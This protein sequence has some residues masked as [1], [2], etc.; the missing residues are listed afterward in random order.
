MEADVRQACCRLPPWAN[1][2]SATRPD[3]LHPVH[4]HVGRTQAPNR[5]ALDDRR[6]RN[7][8]EASALGRLE[9]D[10]TGQPPDSPDDRSPRC[11]FEV[12]ALLLFLIGW[13][14]LARTR[15]MKPLPAALRALGVT[16]ARSSTR[17]RSASMARAD[18]SP[19]RRLAELFPRALAQLRRIGPD[20]RRV[21][22][23]WTPASSVLVSHPIA[24]SSRL[25][26][27]VTK[28][29][30]QYSIDA[31]TL[32]ASATVAFSAT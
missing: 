1:N 4:R 32:R 31:M 29:S 30:L 9:L 7:E 2:R 16:L 23:H 10:D 25:P 27:D 6:Y 5:T 8:A 15:S 17:H 22:D 28:T 24:R 14:L 12:D 21:P 3:P 13:V 26:V 19:P 11:R 20:K 18:V